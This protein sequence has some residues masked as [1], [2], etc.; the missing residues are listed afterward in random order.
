[1]LPKTPKEAVQSNAGHLCE[2]LPPLS[3]L[4][5]E[6]EDQRHGL[7]DEQLLHEGRVCH[8]PTYHPASSLQEGQSDSQK[9]WNGI[10]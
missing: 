5:G 8:Q 3:D 1:M 6:T 2:V 7:L 4:I 10:C 9:V